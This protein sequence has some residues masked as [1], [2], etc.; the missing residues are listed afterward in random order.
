[1]S[2]NK[3]YDE[4]SREEL[5]EE[6]RNREIMGRSSMNK[7]ELRQALEE[8]DRGENIEGSVEEGERDKSPDQQQADEDA[9]NA[10]QQNM[11]PSERGSGEAEQDDITGE[12]SAPHRS[13]FSTAT[14]GGQGIGFEGVEQNEEARLAED[15]S[16]ANFNPPGSPGPQPQRSAAADPNAK[17]GQPGQ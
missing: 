15:E 5:E 9:A 14:G 8:S 1:M 6:A 7:D 3:N 13:H 11:Q 2:E 16:L 12:G 17:Y 10:E 4:M